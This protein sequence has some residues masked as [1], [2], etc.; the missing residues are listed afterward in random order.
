MVR[1]QIQRPEPGPR[2]VSRTA[3]PAAGGEGE[4]DSECEQAGPAA[5]KDEDFIIKKPGEISFTSGIV[6]EGRVEKPQVLLVLTK[7]RIK[8]DPVVFQQ[9]F[10]KNITDPLRYNTFEISKGSGG[11]E[12]GGSENRKSRRNQ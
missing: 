10:L 2:P 3:G 6:I 11:D 12:M 9:S 4:G 7:E 1:S 8:V 5:Q